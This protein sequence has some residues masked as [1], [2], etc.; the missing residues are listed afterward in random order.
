[1]RLHTAAMRLSGV[2]PE[3]LCVSHVYVGGSSKVFF[4]NKPHPASRPHR[5]Y[6]GERFTDAC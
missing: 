5:R 2:H 3:A 6:P 4:V 1:M